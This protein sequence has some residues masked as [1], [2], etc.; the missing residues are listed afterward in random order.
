MIAMLVVGGEGTLVG[1]LFGVALLT[2]LPTV[3]QPLALYKTLA[4]GLLLV[5]VVRYLPGGIFGTLAQ[6]LLRPAPR[7]HAKAAT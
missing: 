6:R 3:F 4:E 2:L 7:T 5:L 1:S